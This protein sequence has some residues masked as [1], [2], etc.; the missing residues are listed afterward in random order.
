MNNNNPTNAVLV[1]Q[2]NWIELSEQLSKLDQLLIH[3]DCLN[4]GVAVAINNQVVTKENWSTQV[5]NNN[6]KINIFGAIAGG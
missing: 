1:N 2:E 6:D 4:D 5:I 3:L